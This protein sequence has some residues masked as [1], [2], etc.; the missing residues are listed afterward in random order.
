LNS[1]FMLLIIFFSGVQAEGKHNSVR[2]LNGSSLCSGILEVRSNQSNQQWSSV[3]EADF[4]QQD[5]EVVCR[6]LG[7]GTPVFFQGAL[8]GEVEAPMWTKEFQC[9]GDESGLLDCK[10][11]DSV[12]NTCSPG[13]AV[14]LICSESGDI[15]LVG[16]DNRCEGTLEMKLEEWRPVNVKDGTLKTADVF[17]QLLDCGSVVSVGQTMKTSDKPVWRIMS[18]CVEVQSPLRECM[19]PG[20]SSSVFNLIYS[21]RLLSGSSLCS[22]ILEVRSNQSNQQWSSVCEA[23]FDQQDAEVVCRELGCGTPVFFQ[24]VLFGEVEAPMWTKEFQCA[25]DESGLLDCKSSD[26]V[27]NTCSPGRAVGLICSA[28]VRLVGEASRCAGT[29]EL[30]HLEDWRPVEASQWTLKA[31]SVFCEHLD[32]GSAISLQRREWWSGR[33]LW[34]VNPHCFQRESDARACVTAT[35]SSFMLYLTCSGKLTSVIYG[36]YDIIR[37]G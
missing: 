31:A 7:C 28:P 6:E 1:L 29:L 16:G 4:D 13:R 5:A 33:P 21:V 26:S 8:F 30:K 24:G 25:G 12:G 3:C 15:R 17:C 34:S 11:S 18:H 19:I 9:A 14:G 23:D 35:Q 27:G 22:G 36:I 37:D 2:L 20:S 10:S 32:C